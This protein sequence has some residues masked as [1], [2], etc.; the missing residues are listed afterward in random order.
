MIT[1]CDKNDF[2]DVVDEFIAMKSED[3]NFTLFWTYMTMG[4]MLL[5]YTRAD[6]TDNWP[7][8]VTLILSQECLV[9]LK[10]TLNVFWVIPVPVL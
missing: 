2:S 6:R 10:G 5:C 7:L 3:K 4:Q 9:H 1:R 8:R